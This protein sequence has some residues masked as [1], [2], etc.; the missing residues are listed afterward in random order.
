MPEREKATG[1]LLDVLIGHEP[2]QEHPPIPPSVRGAL[3]E[4]GEDLWHA[5]TDGDFQRLLLM[6]ESIHHR[7]R[8]DDPE[9]A[10]IHKHICGSCLRDAFLNDEW[11][12]ASGQTAPDENERRLG[13]RQTWREAELQTQIGRAG[14]LPLFVRLALYWAAQRSGMVILITGPN[15]E[16]AE[17]R[18]GRFTRIGLTDMTRSVQRSLTAAHRR[19]T[20]LHAQGQDGWEDDTFVTRAGQR[21]APPQASAA[22][23]EPV[24]HSRAGAP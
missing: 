4:L 17:V 11:A 5:V 19:L 15:H 1:R 24:D 23:D 20:E 6:A 2:R 10:S 18:L 9:H 8:R 14:R 13:I 22:P 21:A 16:T 3:N 12:S 7:R